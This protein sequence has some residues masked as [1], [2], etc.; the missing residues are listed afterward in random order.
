MA[1]RAVKCFLGLSFRT[2][3]AFL[4]F[5]DSW[6]HMVFGGESYPEEKT[7]NGH[8]ERLLCQLFKGL[9]QCEQVSNP[10]I[11]QIDSGMLAKLII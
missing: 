5:I 7:K 4:L 1:Y 2:P 6:L 3:G 9:H 11:I 8:C 10:K